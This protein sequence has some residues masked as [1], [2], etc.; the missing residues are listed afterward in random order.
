MQ[1]RVFLSILAAAAAVAAAPGAARAE[2]ELTKALAE[3]TRARASVKNLVAPF[4]QVRTIGLLETDGESEGEMILVRPD[5]LRWELKGKD[6][7]TYWISPEGFAFATPS[8]STSVGK[9]GAGRFDLVLK[10]MLTLLGGDLESL[11]TR[12]ELS[13]PSREGGIVLLA[14]P[15]SD[16]VKKHVRSLE[17]AAGPEPWSVKRVVLEEKNGDKSVIT[18][19]KVERDVAV[20]PAKMKPPAK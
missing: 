9:G 20:D 8:G 5:R 14:K 15:K 12:Y 11:R 13:I 10:D 18:F 7:I 2:D 3:I 16:D 19:G 6:A 17:M 4:K 1:R